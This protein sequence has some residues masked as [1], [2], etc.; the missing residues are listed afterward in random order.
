ML[1]PK[2]SVVQYAHDEE[3]VRKGRKKERELDDRDVEDIR[4]VVSTK[5][6]RRFFWKLL[7]VSGVLAVNPA[8]NNTVFYTEGQRS[9]GVSLMEDLYHADPDKFFLMRKEAE[10]EEQTYGG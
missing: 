9:I 8:C 3:Q 4:F 1:D 6:G 10:E 5:P 2:R 7:R